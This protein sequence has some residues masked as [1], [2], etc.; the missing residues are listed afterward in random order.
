MSYS[1]RH[2]KQAMIFSPRLLSI[3]GMISAEPRPGDVAKQVLNRL[4]SIA[5]DAEIPGPDVTELTGTRFKANNVVVRPFGLEPIEE[6]RD[7]A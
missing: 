6:E 4:R 1:V 7:G 2:G 3:G 5:N